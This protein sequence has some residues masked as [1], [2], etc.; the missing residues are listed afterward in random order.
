MNVFCCPYIK[1][2]EE[3][4]GFLVE[5]EV[6]LAFQEVEEEVVLLAFQEVEEEVALLAFREGV[7]EV[8]VLLAFQE[9][10]EE[11]VVL[12]AFQE[13]VEEEGVL[14][15]FQVVVAVEGEEVEEPEYLNKQSI[16]SINNRDCHYCK[17]TIII[18]IITTY[19]NIAFL[20]QWC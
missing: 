7:E 17:Y 11:E 6:P 16:I 10:V 15:A 4:L 18:I 19:H 2:E 20:I 5:G 3:Y 1:D 13:G 9:G 14:L 12:L 8:V